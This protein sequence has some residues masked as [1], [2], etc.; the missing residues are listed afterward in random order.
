MQTTGSPSGAAGVAGAEGTGQIVFTGNTITVGQGLNGSIPF[1]QSGT[2]ALNLSII[3]LGAINNNITQDLNG[4]AGGNLQ[5]SGNSFIGEG[6][7]TLNLGLAGTG[8]IMI[9]TAANTISVAGSPGNTITG[10]STIGL[11]NNT[12]VLAG[13][14]ALT[15][16]FASDPDTLIFTPT[17][18]TVMVNH[19]T[20]TNMVLDFQGFGSALTAAELQADTTV[21]GVNTFITIGTGQ[22]ELTGFTGTIPSG[23]ETINPQCFRIGTRI[24]TPDGPVAVEDL[25]V[26]GLV[27]IN[28]GGA[29]PIRWIGRRRFDCRRHPMPETVLPIRIAA[30]AFGESQPRRDL[31]LS[32]DHAIYAEDVL[33][34]V[35][36]LIDGVSVA[37][38]MVD[39]VTYYH[40]ELP[41]H[42]VMI[43]EGLPAESYLDI[44][45]RT[46]FAGGAHVAIPH[47]SWCREARHAA[48]VWET[49]GAAPV[50]LS[51]P[52]IERVR[53]R[54]AARAMEVEANKAA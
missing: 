39:E 6:Q 2:L 10:F 3:D 11:D 34:P 22:I 12:T 45:D 36:C 40:V 46:F 44:G 20:D 25:A 42:A 52:E 47:P 30:H 9:D 51:G 49:E 53:D 50:C 24:A 1:N 21:N 33:I 5:F 35:K 15:L 8:S 23:D 31:F 16:N 27:T 43:A 54:L 17:S 28:D 26:G 38:V 14:G 18:G 41:R 37:R 32:P 48:L 29:L 7:S 13:A 4:A 19:A